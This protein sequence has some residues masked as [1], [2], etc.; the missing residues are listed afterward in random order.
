MLLRV[1]A[2]IQTKR[3]ITNAANMKTTI[4]NASLSFQ[5]VLV[6]EL[7][8]VGGECWDRGEPPDSGSASVLVIVDWIK[9]VEIVG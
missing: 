9:G 3:P 2:S 7:M 4:A 1:Q 8:L 6:V 5:T